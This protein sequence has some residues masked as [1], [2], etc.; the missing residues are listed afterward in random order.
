MSLNF[1]WI[2]VWRRGKH[3]RQFLYGHAEW[4]KTRKML[5]L[6]SHLRIKIMALWSVSHM[7][8]QGSHAF[9]MFLAHAL[10]ECALFRNTTYTKLRACTCW[11]ISRVCLWRPCTISARMRARCAQCVCMHALSENP[12]YL[13]MRTCISLAYSICTS[14]F[15]CLVC[16]VHKKNDT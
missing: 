8:V 16:A 13:E 6:D 14:F 2:K 3:F 10:R 1:I 7:F 15:F 11:L 9:A 4:V 5:E 12:T